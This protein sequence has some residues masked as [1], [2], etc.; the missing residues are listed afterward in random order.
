M[1]IAFLVIIYIVLPLLGL[2]LCVAACYFLFRLLVALFHLIVDG[3]KCI[4]FNPKVNSMLTIIVLSAGVLFLTPAA[5]EYFGVICVIVLYSLLALVL[6]DCIRDF[7]K[8]RRLYRPGN[9]LDSLYVTKSLLSLF[10]F[11]LARIVFLL[12]VFPRVLFIERSEVAKELSTG[13]IWDR[14][15]NDENRQVVPSKY[16]GKVKLYYFQETLDHLKKKGVI[17]QDTE[18]ADHEIQY[19]SDKV[20]RRHPQA[21]LPDRPWYEEWFPFMFREKH[22]AEW[23]KY[24]KM[25]DER[26]NAKLKVDAA[27]KRNLSVPY[28]RVDYIQKLQELITQAMSDKAFYPLSEIK[29]FPELTSLNLLPYPDSNIDNGVPREIREQWVDYLIIRSL[30]PLVERGIFE[31]DEFNRDDV[32]DNHAYRYVYSEKEMV[33]IHADDDL[34]LAIDDDD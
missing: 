7:R 23:E 33:V 12:V 11:G 21:Y 5:L 19:A 22:D 4:L 17:F 14:S 31:E 26:R 27:K 29:H 24:R 15:I 20:D 3:I 6:A 8:S 25:D 16:L 34:R 28:F 30:Q 18:I 13:L 32:L 9:A 1:T 2:A 10:T